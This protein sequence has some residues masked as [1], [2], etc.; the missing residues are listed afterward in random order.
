MAKLIRPDGSITDVHPS[1][2]E[3]FAWKDLF[4]LVGATNVSVIALSP[5]VTMVFSGSIP[6]AKTNEKATLIV[7]IVLADEDYRIH[8]NALFLTEAETRPLVLKLQ[9]QPNMRD[10][11]GCRPN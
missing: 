11:E 8:G 1:N 2:S 6:Q 7:Q 4:D 10:T 5:R 3:G 9:S